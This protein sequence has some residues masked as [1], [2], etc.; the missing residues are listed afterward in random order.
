MAVSNVELRVNATQAVTALKNVDVQAKKFNTTITG[1]GGKLKATAGSLKP[2]S[3]GLAATGTGATAAASGFTTLG[4]SIAPLILPLVGIGAAFSTI[5]T[6]LRTFSDR[7]SDVAILTQ[8]LQN[9]GASTSSL[10]ELQKAADKLGK[11]TLFDQEDFTRGFNLL[12]SF[13]NIGVDS[14]TRVAQSAADIAEVNQV[15]VN[16]SFMQLAK[17]LQDPERNLS[18]LNRSGIAFT[19]TQ[20]DVIKEL[21]KTNKV[22]EA[23]DMILRIVEESYNQLAQAA[24]TGLAG[25]TDSLGESFRD[26]S[27]VLGEALNPALTAAVE[28]LTGLVNFL[29]SDGGQTAAVIAGIGL[30]VKGL[31]VAIPFAVLQ[32]KALVAGFSMVGVKSII[33][34]GGLTGVS[35]TSLL[36]AGSVSKLT[37]AVGALTI[38]A[39]ALPLIALASGFVLLTNSIIK[40]INKQKEFNKL[41]EEGSSSDLQAKIDSV[42]KKIDKL[43]EAKAKADKQDFL[44]FS[45]NQRAELL[46]LEKDLIKLQERL[47]IAQGIELFKDFERSKNAL[48]AKNKELKEIEA[49]LK[50]GTE[51]G[52]KQ[53]DLDQKRK[54][55]T[56]KFGKELADQLIDLEKKNNLLEEGNKKLKKQEEAA[57]ALKEKFM[58]IGQDIE[59]G[60]VSNLADAVEGTKT[61]AQAAVS[62]L[63]DLKRKLIEVAIQ[64]AVS[65][66]GGKIGGFLGKVFGGEKASG[67]QVAAGKTFLVGEKGPELLSMGTSRGFITPNN[68]ISG[69]QSVVNN[70]TVNVDA[71][72][73]SVQGNDADANQFGE[74]LAAAIQAEI[75]NQKR[76]GGLLN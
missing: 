4:S 32:L 3:A 39:N 72:G 21:M 74:Q 63:N 16:T 28:G 22:A 53:F 75:I 17:A 44:I 36:A 24:A 29:N 62:V 73:S 55:L 35:A 40:A 37:V 38:A 69:G 11:T 27:E 31:S 26:F 30:A 49:K 57:K 68:Q 56:E 6:A 33:A 10:N 23:H 64:Q 47:V 48:K 45:P 12:T 67:G 15:D 20:T 61:L 66:I 65:G 13:R 60:I 46:G 51:E 7:Q 50:I 2:L 8:G 42:T 71:S 5:N 18:N 70:I 54:E 58:A 59:K 34:S 43:K 19:K 76:S 25:A 9:L 41:L 52:R 14:Y 1:T